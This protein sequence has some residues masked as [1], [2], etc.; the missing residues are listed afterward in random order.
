M[1][2]GLFVSTSTFGRRNIYAV[3]FIYLYRL[4]HKVLISIQRVTGRLLMAYL[5]QLIRLHGRLQ[6]CQH[7]HI[8]GQ[9]YGCTCASPWLFSLISCVHWRRYDVTCCSL[10]SS[11]RTACTQIC[12]F[13]GGRKIAQNTCYSSIYEYGYQ[14]KKKVLLYVQI[15]QGKEISSFI[16][17]GLPHQ[18]LWGTFLGL[19]R[20]VWLNTGTSHG[21]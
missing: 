3:H 14:V 5:H 13:K 18:I 8:S 15:S 16:L 7:N 17:K 1:V 4:Y 9:E 11:M 10:P 19:C 21:F 12:T 20:Q 2:Y 6:S